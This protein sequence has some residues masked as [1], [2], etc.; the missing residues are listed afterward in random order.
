[1]TD[2]LYY[3]ASPKH[4]IRDHEH[5][6]FW[7]PD[8]RGYVLVVKD[9][10]TGAYKLAEAERLNDGLSCIA[11]PIAAVKALLSPEPY[12]R[13]ANGE[14]A[15]FYD[16]PGPVVDNTRANWN[17]LIAASL[18]TGR[19]YKPKPEVHRRVRRSFAL[20]GSAAAPGVSTSPGETFSGKTPMEQKA[21]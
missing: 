10:H 19:Q 9:G 1:M 17:R 15:R 3:I 21:K 20:A 8:H 13:R 5:I 7:G 6:T 4:T 12:Y 14:A 2:Q 16:M 18:P 11:V